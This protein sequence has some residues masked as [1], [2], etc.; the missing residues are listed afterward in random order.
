ML[1][2]VGNVLLYRIA[3]SRKPKNLG[4]DVT[5][6]LRFVSFG[7]EDVLLEKRIFP[8]HMCT[9]KK[10]VSVDDII[11]KT[12]TNIVRVVIFFIF[13]VVFVGGYVFLFL[14]IFLFF[15]LPVHLFVVL[16]SSVVKGR[17]QTTEFVIEINK[18]IGTTNLHQA[19]VTGLLENNVLLV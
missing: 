11:P 15:G 13:D 9:V 14:R 10:S 2:H 16:G 1:Y 6:N 17:L 18:D 19:F 3:H 7:V 12:F 4:I 8:I 5:N